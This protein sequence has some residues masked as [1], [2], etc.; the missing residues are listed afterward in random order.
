MAIILTKVACASLETLHA[1]TGFV[2]LEWQ[3]FP[4]RKA[5]FPA[6]NFTGRSLSSADSAIVAGL[7][8]AEGSWGGPPQ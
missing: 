3:A 6:G 8:P 7:T 4:M 1:T 2:G 5:G